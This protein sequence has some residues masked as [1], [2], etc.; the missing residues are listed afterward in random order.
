MGVQGI[1]FLC[2]FDELVLLYLV[3]LR[4]NSKVGG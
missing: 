4:R 1:R 2:R 3:I